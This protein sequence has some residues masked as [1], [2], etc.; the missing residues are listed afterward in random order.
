MTIAIASVSSLVSGHALQ[1]GDAGGLYFADNGKGVFRETVCMGDIAFDA[2]AGRLELLLPAGRNAQ[3]PIW[4]YCPGSH[5]K[6]WA[7]LSS[8]SVPDGQALQLIPTML[9]SFSRQAL[10]NVE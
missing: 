1:G 3:T 9:T 8:G 7:C 6:H 5:G 2:L 10:Q 4:L